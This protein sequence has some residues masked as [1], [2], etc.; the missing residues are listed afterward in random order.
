MKP[1]YPLHLRLANVR[2]WLDARV[3]LHGKDVILPENEAKTLH[4]MIRTQLLP[5]ALREDGP[6]RMDLVLCEHPKKWTVEESRNWYVLA[7]GFRSA[8]EATHWVK[9]ELDTNAFTFILMK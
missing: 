2:R 1:N 9:K 6:Y 8:H 7:A 3:P 4:T 5:I